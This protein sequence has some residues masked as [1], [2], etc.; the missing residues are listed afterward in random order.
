[1]Y[2]NA[3]YVPRAI[4]TPYEYICREPMLNNSGSMI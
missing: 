2:K 4:N 1:M 3:K